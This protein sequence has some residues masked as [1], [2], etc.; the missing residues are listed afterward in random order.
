MVVPTF[1]WTGCFVGGQLGWGWQ[2]NKISQKNQHTI[3]TTVFLSSSSGNTDS[4]GPV[5]GGQ[6][7]CDYQVG[8]GFVIGAQGTFLASDITG[9]AQDPHNGAIDVAQNGGT[10]GIISGGSIGVRTNWIGSATARLGFTG[11]TPQSM[12]YVRGGAAWAQTQYDLRSSAVNLFNGGYT[13]FPNSALFDVTHSGWTIGAGLEWMFATNWSAFAEYNY[14][15]FSAA[16]ISVNS[17][18]GD[19]STMTSQPNISTVMVGV[20]YRLNMFGMR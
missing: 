19:I 3:G 9:V 11:W 17:E 8:N 15:R 20:N 13:A 1:S 18:P 2:R 14:Y 7:G 12:F 16:S 5:F 6:V 4:H 10:N